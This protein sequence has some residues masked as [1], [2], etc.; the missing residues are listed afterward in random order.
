MCACAYMRVR[1]CVKI[2]I[3][4]KKRREYIVRAIYLTVMIYVK[5]KL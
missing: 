3:K 4:Y 5:T 1:V 2:I